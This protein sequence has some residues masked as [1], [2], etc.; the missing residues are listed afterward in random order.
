[1][2]ETYTFRY[3][4]ADGSFNSLAVVQLHDR[5]CAEISAEN[6]MPKNATSVEIWSDDDLFSTELTHLSAHSSH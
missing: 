4:N 1:M 3:L 5:H 2:T 6:L